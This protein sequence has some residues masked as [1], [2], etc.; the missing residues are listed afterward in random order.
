MTA[1]IG[2]IK[3]KLTG[4]IG[5]DIVI[6]VEAGRRKTTVHEGTLAETYPAVFVVELD[7]CED[8][9]ERV[10]FSY[11]DVLTDTIEIDFPKKELVASVDEDAAEE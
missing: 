6:T 11:A 1:T 9:Y 10:S 8:S 7:D 3:N 4:L 2:D 5:E